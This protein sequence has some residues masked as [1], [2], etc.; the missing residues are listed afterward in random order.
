MKTYFQ[1]LMILV[2][3]TMDLS[4]RSEKILFCYKFRPGEYLTYQTNRQDNVLFGNERQSDAR[5]VN[6][7]LRET[8]EVKASSPEVHHTISYHLDS[9]NISPDWQSSQISER[10]LLQ[11]FPKQFADTLI[12]MSTNGYPLLNQGQFHFNQLTLPLSEFPLELNEGWEF[13]F[14]IPDGPFSSKQ[15]KSVVFG[16]G[17]LYDFIREDSRTLARFIVNTTQLFEGECSISNESSRF[18]FNRE[19]EIESTHLVYFDEERGVITK[20]VTDQVIKEQRY[21]RA[22]RLSFTI[23][24]KSTTELVDWDMYKGLLQ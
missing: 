3:L 16:Q 20:I 6:I 2:T 15:C 11:H 4:A 13:E 17:M 19:G 7:H 5:K 9:V 24:S 8:L 14:E 21:T 1:I 23:T 22:N 18:V 10:D 12:H